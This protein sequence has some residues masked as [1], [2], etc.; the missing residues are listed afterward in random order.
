MAIL[1]DTLILFTSDHGES[2]DD[3][4][5]WFDHGTFVYEEQ[6]RVP[7]IVRFPGIIP[8]MTI[9]TRVSLADIAPTILHLLG[10]PIPVDMDGAPV[11]PKRN[12]ERQKDRY[13][14]GEGARGAPSRNPGTIAGLQGKQF[15]VWQKN[16]KVIRTRRQ[17][18]VEYQYFDLTEDPQELGTRTTPR[19]D[20][21]R[22]LRSVLSR[23]VNDY[24][25]RAKG[26]GPGR[27]SAPLK[28]ESMTMT[29][30]R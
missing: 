15:A 4:I 10:L 21:E 6:L 27:S 13:L 12:A 26:V 14:F 2:L 29:G 16:L 30:K 1:D 17:L 5:R 19:I 11:L 28:A 24:Y 25:K 18:T 22:E 23:F 9:D 8:P 3:H 20:A 7:L